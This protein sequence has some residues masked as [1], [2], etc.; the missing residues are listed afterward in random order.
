VENN[1]SYVSKVK[2]VLRLLLT[3][4]TTLKRIFGMMS[5]KF[6]VDGIDNSEHYTH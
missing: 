3:I 6:D 1:H 4:N 5:E 2:R